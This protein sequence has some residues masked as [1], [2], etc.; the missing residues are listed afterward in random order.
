MKRRWFSGI[1]AAVLLLCSGCAGES[2]DSFKNT[3][4]NKPEPTTAVTQPSVPVSPETE[5]TV[6]ATECESDNHQWGEPTYTWIN[7]DTACVAQRTCTVPGCNEVETETATVTVQTVTDEEGEP[8]ENQS[9]VEFEQEDFE[10]QTTVETLSG[11]EPAFKVSNV[12]GHPGEEITV[13]IWIE[14]NPGIIAAAMDVHYDPQKLKLIR[15]EDTGLLNGGFFSDSVEKN[16]YYVSWNDPLAP[17]NNTEN[18]VLVELVFQ[19]LEGVEG[20]TEISLTYHPGNVFDWD[21]NNVTF[22]TA[23]GTVEILVD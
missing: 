16:P 2:N 3:V 20:E 8:S 18:G 6:P 22:S 21:L 5:A 7:D 14:N 23:G 19:I 17:E 11:T 13:E 12:S 4:I 9:Y 10:E 1:C 15:S